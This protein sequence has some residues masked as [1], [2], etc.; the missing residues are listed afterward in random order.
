METGVESS[1]AGGRHGGRGLELRLLGPLS[2]R[3]DGAE[4]ALPASRKVRGLLAYLA[5]APRP[6]RREALCDLLWDVPNDPRGELRWTMSK[7][8]GLLD[9]PGRRRVTAGGEAVA[10]DLGDCR[11]DAIEALRALEAGVEALD[12]DRLAAL[13]GLF[14]GDFLEGLEIE[15]APAF[16]WW[17]VAQRRLFRDGHARVLERMIAALPPHAEAP[18]GLVEKWLALAPFDL[19]AHGRLLERLA[20]GRR[21]REGEEHLAATARLFEAEGI[22]WMPLRATWQAVRAAPPAAVAV[23][24]PVAPPT[25]MQP[26]PAPPRRGSIAV[27]PFA[28]RTG[29][30][31]GGLADGL[32]HDVITRLAK[33]RSLQVIAWG[34]VA[35]LAGRGIASD[36]AGRLLG[37][38][39][40]TTGEVGQRNGMA[41]VSVELVDTRS[42]AIV[43]TELF[44]RVSDAFEALDEIG[45]RIVASVSIEIEAAE[46]NR[47]VLKPPHSLDA[48]E[49]YHRG[50]WHAYRFSMEDNEQAQGL[51]RGAVRMDPTFAR[52]H[53]GL[54]FTHFQNA[55]LFRIHDREREVGRALDAAGQSL[56]ADDRDP[57]AHWAMGRALWLRGAPEQAVAE[58]ETSV[59]LSPNFVLGHYTL[60]FVNSQSGDAGSAIL[61]ADHSRHLSPFDPLLF[62]M[63]GARAM[64]LLRLGRHDEAADWAI[65][66]TARPNAHVHILGIAALCLAVAGRLDEARGFVA[67]IRRAVPGYDL[68]DFLAAFRFAP[69]A[70]ALF[71][72][73]ARRIGMA[74]P[75]TLRPVRL[76]PV[77]A[78]SKAKG[79]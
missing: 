20:R 10:L 7:I 27:M 74:E 68:D 26:D 39:Y 23:S 6:V 24:P 62:A 35:S 48:W 66:A 63:L 21:L 42:G 55:F 57:S 40:L 9:E 13:A 29:G 28:D 4:L 51:F 75:A 1:G 69:D 76:A 73:G 19:R 49:S 45:S 78:G 61:S 32:V 2:V 58:L 70:E 64:A 17:L 5:L 16:G 79:R 12:R 77:N 37:V 38:D 47:A 71:R 54:S 65:R 59:D 15:R 72:S 67:L 11:V 41:V 52:A 50:L 33:L 18:D 53:A 8:R 3:R 22:D 36:E 60:A 31:G 25:A 30:A 56:V 46:R 34:S 14:A 43:W 44:E